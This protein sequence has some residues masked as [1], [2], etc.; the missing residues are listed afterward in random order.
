MTGPR[1]EELCDRSAAVAR[2]ADLFVVAAR[3]AAVARG[4]FTV[5]LS[6]GA[7]PSVLYSLLSGPRRGE[8]PWEA[9]E[10][11]FG[12]ERCVPPDDPRSN[13]RMAWET[14]LEPAGVP[15]SRVHRMEGELPPDVGATRY[16][17][18]LRDFF[19]A[20]A[21][22]RFD[23]VLLGLGADG[24]T[25]SLFPGSSVL[26]ERRHWVIASEAPVEPRRRLTLTLPVFDA[27]AETL[28]LVTGAEKARAA[29]EA[30]NGGEAPAALVRPKDGRLTW[31]LDA[32]A[33]NLKTGSGLDFK[34]GQT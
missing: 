13:Y 6:G 3:E 15:E 2:A 32:A 12:D 33:A 8:V 18:A 25:A 1:V 24:H 11:F 17:Q 23:F 27:A 26:V 34:F 7:T 29:A 4:R 22:P 16:E 14:L 9:L 30:L 19:G 20:G 21:P 28:C 5:A 10:V 31:I